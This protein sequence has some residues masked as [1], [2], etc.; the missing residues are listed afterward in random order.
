M[1]L[2]QDPALDL[3]STPSEATV[4]P[5]PLP[6]VR[7]TVTV[8][9]ADLAGSTALGERLDPESLRR[10][11]SRVFAEMRAVVEAHGGTVEKFSGDDV[12]AVFGVP[13]AHEDDAVRGIRAAF[14]VRDALSQLGEEVVTQWGT[15]LDV[16]IGLNT[17]EVIAGA[18][19]G[20]EP[21]V[22]G[23]ADTGA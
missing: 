8:L 23:D 15:R 22:T 1:I 10:L 9:F 14:V 16:R 17:G 2:T 13:A 21:F 3:G 20:A 6:E 4:E 12:M 11:M 18:K 5:V 7:K 19:E